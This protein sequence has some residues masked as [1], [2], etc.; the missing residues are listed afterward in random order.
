[1][2]RVRNGKLLGDVVFRTSAFKIKKIC[3]FHGVGIKNSPFPPQKASLPCL[4]LTNSV[5]YLML[6]FKRS[7]SL[8]LD[9][10]GLLEANLSATDVPSNIIWSKYF[11]KL[12]HIVC[13]GIPMTSG[14]TLYLK[15]VCRFTCGYPDLICSKCDH[16]A[17]SSRIAL[18][19]AHLQVDNVILRTKKAV[20][21]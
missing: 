4:N 12:E 9:I 17:C 2:E 21:G 14:S 18:L 11:S 3:D 13:I 15:E 5:G 19:A 7:S 1:L 16:T 6:D 10:V 8:P 20:S